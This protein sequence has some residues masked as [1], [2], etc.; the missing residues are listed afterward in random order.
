MPS[1]GGG[2]GRD[3]DGQNLGLRVEKRK[4]GVWEAEKR[5]GRKS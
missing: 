2:V 1:G 4:G 3:G 5:A